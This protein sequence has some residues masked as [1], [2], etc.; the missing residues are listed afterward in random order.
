MTSPFPPSLQGAVDRALMTAFGTAELDSVSALSGGLSGA[1]VFRIRVGGIDYALRLTLSRDAIRDPVRGF[2][3]L[4]IAAGV[5]LSPAV[6][7]ADA[8]SGVAITDFVAARPLSD[9]PRE[10]GGLIVELAQA[11]RVL[12]QAPDFPP[13]VDY[14]AGVQGLLD[15]LIASGLLASEATRD[16]AACYA[17]LAARYRT[18]PS[19]LV[20]S[21]NDLN[22]GN[23]VSDGRRLW[24][25]DWEA[26][27]L[28]DRYVD[29]ATAANWFDRGPR[30]AALLLRTYFNREP[31]A[32]EQ[33][34]FEVMRT[35]NHVFAGA[36]FLSGAAAE[37][38]GAALDDP[39]LAA[40]PLGELHAGLASGGFAFDAWE[41]RVTYGKARLARA[42]ADLKTDALARALEIAARDD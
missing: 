37:R 22:P 35:V 34:R 21:H 13:L 18:R 23:I 41:N 9:Y 5:G 10:G 14:L 2:A 40:P 3:C 20:S 4:R 26:A 36:V 17:D 19:D 29:L 33:A 1:M 28:A 11:I 16:L 27:F 25:I 32:Q 24:L 30:T 12:H 8:E 31:T 38:P 6:R 39:T 7:Y 15:R 42:L